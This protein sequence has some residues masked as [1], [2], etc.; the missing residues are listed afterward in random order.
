MFLILNYSVCFAHDYLYQM[1]SKNA[2]LELQVYTKMWQAE[3][4]IDPWSTKSTR[5]VPTMVF[6]GT[7]C[8]ISISVAASSL[9][10][11]VLLYPYCSTPPL[12]SFAGGSHATLCLFANPVCNCHGQ[13]SSCAIVE[14]AMQAL[15]HVFVHLPVSMS[16]S[17]FTLLGILFLL[18]VCCCLAYLVVWCLLSGVCCWLC[19]DPWPS[20][21]GGLPWCL[22]QPF[23]TGRLANQTESG[24]CRPVCCIPP[25]TLLINNLF[26]TCFADWKKNNSSKSCSIYSSCIIHVWCYS[27]MYIPAFAPL[28]VFTFVL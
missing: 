7:I 17:H 3:Y 18:G 8:Y 21:E 27:F 24:P 4:N 28:P 22:L 11:Y 2:M 14:N 23:S 15:S 6:S 9:L 16:S 13:G 10:I 26:T 19:S 5:A 12:S 25:L 20:Y 1:Q